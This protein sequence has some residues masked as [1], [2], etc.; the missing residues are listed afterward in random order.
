MPSFRS[1]AAK[2][3]HAVSQRLD[4]TSRHDNRDDGQIHSRGTARNFE[5]A[6]TQYEQFAQ[7]NR[8][9]DLRT[10]TTETAQQY[11]Q[12][13]QEAGW[14]QKTLDQDRQALQCHLQTSLERVQ[15]IKETAL[16][17]RSYTSAQ[18]N[19][20]ASHQNSRNALS[21]EIAHSAGLRA[22]ELLTIRPITERD[23]SAHRE[24][25]AYRFTGR[26]GE[27]Y[28]VKG[29]GG[30]VRAVMIPRDL[31]ARLE[32]TKLDRGPRE[33]MDRGIKYQQY[34]DIGGG[35]NW[36]SSFS[37]VSTN[38]LGWSNGAHGVRHSYAQ[39]RMQE[40]QRAGYS[41]NDALGIVAQEVGHFSPHTT[42]AYLR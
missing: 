17:T 21:T 8:L 27:L 9:G 40:M 6:L 29:K 25:S 16:N 13:R 14:S 15:S 24:W 1:S 35:K 12:E 18:I 26:T 11:L 10:A 28:S 19:E 36:T 20:I 39:E 31:A 23:I 33:V 42:E 3:A 2:A 30:L 7:A 37:R 32:A 34:Y 4:L 5:Q 41:Y 38:N 22:H